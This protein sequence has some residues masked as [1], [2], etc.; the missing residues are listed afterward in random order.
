MTEI[1]FII[2]S[3]QFYDGFI[4]IALL[5]TISIFLTFINN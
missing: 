1:I 5:K 2:T 4:F 3:A